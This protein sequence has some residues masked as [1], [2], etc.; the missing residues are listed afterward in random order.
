MAEPNRTKDTVFRRADKPLSD[1][2]MKEIAALIYDTDLYIYPAMFTSR[3]EAETI[4]PKMIRAGDQMFRRENM[5]VA[6][7]GIHV[8][9][10]LIW[11]RGPLRWNKKI[12]EKC[13]GRAEHIDRVVMEYFDLFA[14]AR[15]DMVSL[16]RIS[17]KEELRGTGI[18][19]ALV[20]TFLEAEKG[21][22]QLFVLADNREAVPFF[23]KKGFRVRETRPG[24]SLDYRAL[25]CFWMTREDH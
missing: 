10:V 4:I 13:G 6:M 25:P 2:Q 22:C 8:A 5:F 14:E 11:M 16:V 23:Q 19:G 21:S 7:K 3:Q 15:A 12:Y 1:A 9:G 18:G 24:F 20:D 17:V